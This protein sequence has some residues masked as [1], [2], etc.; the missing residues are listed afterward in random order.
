MHWGPGQ[1][2]LGSRPRACL[3]SGRS[4]P[5]GVLSPSEHPPGSCSSKRAPWSCR[6]NPGRVRVGTAEGEPGEDAIPPGLGVRPPGQQRIWLPSVRAAPSSNAVALLSPGPP[7]TPHALAAIADS[8]RAPVGASSFRNRRSRGPRSRLLGVPIASSQASG[9]RETPLCFFPESLS[10][11]PTGCMSRRG[12]QLWPPSS[13]PPASP[14]GCVQEKAA[15]RALGA[16]GP[17]VPVLSNGSPALMQRSFLKPWRL[18]APPILPVQPTSS[19]KSELRWGQSDHCVGWCRGAWGPAAGP[20][21]EP[22]QTGGGHARPEAA[23]AAQDPRCSPRPRGGHPSRGASLRPWR[24]PLEPLEATGSPWL[25][26]RTDRWVV[27]LGPERPDATTQR[28]TQVL[29]TCRCPSLALALAHGCTPARTRVPAS[30]TMGRG[31]LR[32]QPEAPR[33]RVLKPSDRQ[34]PT[35]VGTEAPT[36]VGTPCGG[37]PGGSALGPQRASVQIVQDLTPKKETQSPRPPERHGPRAQPHRDTDQPEEEEEE[38]EGPL[39]TRLSLVPRGGIGSSRLEA[40]RGALSPLRG[41]QQ[42]A[43]RPP[44]DAHGPSLGRHRRPVRRGPQRFPGEERGRDGALGAW[45]GRRTPPRTPRES[46]PDSAASGAPQAIPPRTQSAGAPGAPCQGEGPRRPA[47]AHRSS[48]RAGGGVRRS[49]SAI[50]VALRRAGGARHRGRAP[51]TQALPRHSLPPAVRLRGT[52]APPLPSLLIA[53][54]HGA[55]RGLGS[56]RIGKRLRGE[57]PRLLRGARGG[58]GRRRRPGARPDPHP[59]M[60]PRSRP[61]L[62]TPVSRG[63]SA[64]R[65]TRAFCRLTRGSPSPGAASHRP[66]ERGAPADSRGARP[67]WLLRIASRSAGE[68]GLWRGAH[69]A[70]RRVLRVWGPPAKRGGAHAHSGE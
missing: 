54:S 66:G 8:V 68:P 65:R 58:R 69:P 20:C 14:R 28:C 29:P 6:G 26:P 70:R 42:P 15:G 30:G 37:S 19:W 22:R 62:L 39:G 45:R 24:R 25:C 61:G 67:V 12:P 27:H 38:E 7:T 3:V 18:P 2:M 47:A 56:L 35:T 4:G 57:A 50:A 43:P 44:A 16:G 1:A 34:V 53:F 9:L 10:C 46:E 41:P 52:P 17:A 48:P 13:G 63:M 51:Q 23:I 49:R 11:F 59:M 64:A 36:P 55:E 60:N 5:L 21:S 31:T 40:P 32:P 33:M